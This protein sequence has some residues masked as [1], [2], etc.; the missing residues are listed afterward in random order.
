MARRWSVDTHRTA[1][2]RDREYYRLKAKGFDVGKR[3]S[4]VHWGR[5]YYLF[6]Y[7]FSE[8]LWKAKEAFRKAK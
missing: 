4:E 1:K 2:G 8:G 7:R 3:W 6:Q 5:T